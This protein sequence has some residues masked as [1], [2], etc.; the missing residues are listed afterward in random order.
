[1]KRNE[2][3]ADRV[4]R[5]VIGL[6]LIATSFAL[7][8]VPKIVLLAAGALSLITAATGFCLLYT[9]LGIDTTKKK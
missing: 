7:P 8:G 3:P 1:M 9:L 6:A 4:I 5:A 2:G